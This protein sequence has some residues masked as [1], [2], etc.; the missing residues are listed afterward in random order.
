MWMFERK[1]VIAITNE[2]IGNRNHD[3]L[4]LSLIDLGADDIQRED[5]G[6]MIF[7]KPEQLTKTK[8]AVEQI[9]ISVSD[10]S[11]QLI[12][13]TASDVSGADREKNEALIATLEELDDVSAVHTSL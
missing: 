2:D 6:M 1:G 13:K 3:E 9:G 7:T 5:E 8:E 12:P 4:E 11:L 10:A